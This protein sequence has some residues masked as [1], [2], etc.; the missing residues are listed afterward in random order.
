M[1]LLNALTRGRWIQYVKNRF[2]LSDLGQINERETLMD[3][4]NKT[5]SGSNM[6]MNM[7]MGINSQNI[8]Q[9]FN[10]ALPDKNQISSFQTLATR[11][12]TLANE[13]VSTLPPAIVPIV[14]QHLWNAYAIVFTAM[15]T[16]VYGEGESYGQKVG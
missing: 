15:I 14:L 12:R 3:N 9:F 4:I 6:N 8:D 2:N 11:Y 13:I 1:K 5:G 10:F 16:N 7:N